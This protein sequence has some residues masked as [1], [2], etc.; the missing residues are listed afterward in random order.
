MNLVEEICRKRCARAGL[1][2]DEV[3]EKTQQPN[4]KQFEEDVSRW[5]RDVQGETKRP[6]E[7]ASNE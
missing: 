6:S 7:D 1:P 4:W 3:N 5:V 2:P